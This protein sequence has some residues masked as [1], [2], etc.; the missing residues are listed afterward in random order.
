MS[1]GLLRWFS[2]L[3]NILCFELSGMH[4][5]RKDYFN[6]TGYSIEVRHVQNFYSS[7]QGS[8]WYVT[9]KKGKS[10]ITCSQKFSQ[11]LLWRHLCSW[12]Q[13]YSFTWFHVHLAFRLRSACSVLFCIAP[14]TQTVATRLH[15]KWKEGDKARQESWDQQ[16]VWNGHISYLTY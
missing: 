8:A 5:E 10:L 2:Q 13:M 9:D 3:M 12:S 4:S 1:H 6:L 14:F 7:V 11:I 15:L 16:N